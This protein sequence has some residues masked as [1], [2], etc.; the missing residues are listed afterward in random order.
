M[1]NL[2]L[3]FKVSLNLIIILDD[4]RKKCFTD[5]LLDFFF[6]SSIQIILQHVKCIVYINNLTDY[7][8]VQIA[9]RQLNISI[10]HWFERT[11]TL[12]SLRYGIVHLYYLSWG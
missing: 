3:S 1:H 10:F 8:F 9:L 4:N 2:F 12:L 5:S 11:I 7:E 6:N